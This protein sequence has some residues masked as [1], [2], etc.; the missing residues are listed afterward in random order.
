MR[1]RQNYPIPEWKQV[2]ST[3]IKTGIPFFINWKIAGFSN[4]KYFGTSLQRMK[5]DY[6]NITIKMA[7]LGDLIAI[8]PIK[9]DTTTNSASD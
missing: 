8:N 4:P 2:V 6:P 9:N 1:D 5:P 3:N 7:T